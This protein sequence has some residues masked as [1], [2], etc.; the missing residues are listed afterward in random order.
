M[1]P[2]STRADIDSSGQVGGNLIMAQWQRW[3]GRQAP[4]ACQARQID[5]VRV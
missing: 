4:V 3:H 1:G 5:A 2:T